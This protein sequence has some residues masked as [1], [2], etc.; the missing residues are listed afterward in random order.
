MVGVMPCFIKHSMMADEHGAQQVWSN[1]LVAPPG[2]IISN[3]FFTLQKIN[4]EEQNTRDEREN[5]DN[6]YHPQ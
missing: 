1:T 4:A 2:A 6:V 5:H 3:G